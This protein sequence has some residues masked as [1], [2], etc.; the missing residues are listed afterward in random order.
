LVSR[1]RQE[2]CSPVGIERH[3]FVPTTMMMT[4]RLFP[5]CGGS[6]MK[7]LVSI[8]V[9]VSVVRA[10]EQEETENELRIA[11]TAQDSLVPPFLQQ[12]VTPNFATEDTTQDSNQ[13]LIEET[14]TL[15]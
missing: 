12:Q 4:R 13:E 8:L 10:S 7:F 9:L 15:D 1:A 11:T 6:M 2:S 14:E 3:F 5:T